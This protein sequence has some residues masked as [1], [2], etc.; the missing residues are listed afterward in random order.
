VRQG[1]FG[2]DLE[3]Q[4]ARR[5]DSDKVARSCAAVPRI[6]K[7]ATSVSLVKTRQSAV[8]YPAAPKFNPGVPREEYITHEI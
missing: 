5:S 8:K 1:C 3:R 4:E 2:R 7:L 6:E